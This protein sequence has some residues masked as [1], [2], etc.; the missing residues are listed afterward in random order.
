MKYKDIKTLGKEMNKLEEMNERLAE[1]ELSTLELKERFDEFLDEAYGTVE[2][3]G[4]TYCTSDLLKSTDPIGYRCGFNDWLDAE[5]TEGNLK[6]IEGLYYPTQ[7]W[8]AIVEE[9][10]VSDAD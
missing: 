5:I 6:E 10:S 7:E 8:D 4:L 3:A 1:L 9:F 2:V